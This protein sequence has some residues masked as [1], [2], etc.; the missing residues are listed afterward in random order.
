MRT[1]LSLALL[2]SVA[3]TAC[4]SMPLIVEDEASDQ[5]SGLDEVQFVSNVAGF[6]AERDLAVLFPLEADPY[7]RASTRTPSGSTLLS[8]GMVNQVA[9]AFDGTFAEG[10]IGGESIYEDWRLVSARIVPCAPVARSPALAP[11]SVCWPPER[12]H[13]VGL[14]VLT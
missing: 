2:A 6:P 10:A 13:S 12:P 11:A 14:R 7:I 8:S 4:Q 3:S 5:Q 9:N 1:N